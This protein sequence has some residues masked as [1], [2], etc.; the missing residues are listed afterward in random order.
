[1]GKMYKVNI[2]GQKIQRT[3]EEVCEDLGFIA[4]IE[5]VK[6]NSS[7]NISWTCGRPSEIKA[8]YN[9]C[10]EKNYGMSQRL[11]DVFVDGY[12]VI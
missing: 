12:W 5:F 10:S 9:A 11:R 4:S 6:I 8:L 7:G 2:N 1:M 3:Y